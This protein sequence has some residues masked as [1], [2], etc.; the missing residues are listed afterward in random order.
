MVRKLKIL[1]II[2]LLIFLIFSP[3]FN[4][5][6]VKFSYKELS[7]EPHESIYIE[8]NDDFTVE[9]G[10]TGGSGKTNDPYI[11]NNWEI[12][13]ALED[14]ITVRNTTVYFKIMSCFIKDGS[15]NNDGIVFINVTNGI[16]EFNSINGNRNGIMFR[17]Q[18]P[19]NENCENNIIRNNSLKN[20]NFNGIHFEHS[21]SNYHSKNVIMKNNISQNNMGIYMITSAENQIFSNYI[22]SNDEGGI[23]LDM[24]ECG[25]EFNKIHHNNL[26]NNG[27]NQAYE[28]GGPR[29]IWDDG[30]PSGGNYWSDYN[31]SDN[32]GDGIGDIPYDIPGG[33]N[34]DN[35]P[36]MEPWGGLNLPPIK[37]NIEGPTSGIVGIM[38]NFSFSSLDPNSDNI[39]FW[40]DWGDGSIEEWI[41]PYNSGEKIIINHTWKKKDDYIIKAKSKDVF[42]QESDLSLYDIKIPRNSISNNFILFRLLN[43]LTLFF[44]IISKFYLII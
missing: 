30:Y 9:N 19:G 43:K 38:Y 22:I 21:S 31:G 14:G 27:D 29:N 24:C 3:I 33:Y 25:G 44:K 2:F 26:V 42:Y 8:G 1:I 15:I 5:R 36:L 39:Y 16:I 28:M 4:A 11:I 7:Y 10:I 12:S 34:K 35:Y 41:G 6:T 20:N 37:P 23:F 40:I 13:S 32:N 18:Y 17:T